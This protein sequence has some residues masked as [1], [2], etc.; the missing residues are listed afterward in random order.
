MMRNQ[1]A[2]ASALIATDSGTDAGGALHMST[3]GQQYLGNM[4]LTAHG[5]SGSDHGIC[6]QRNNSVGGEGC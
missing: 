5:M 4:Q 6:L 2:H 3:N 1:R